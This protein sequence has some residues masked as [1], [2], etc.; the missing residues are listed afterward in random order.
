MKTELDG[1]KSMLAAKPNISVGYVYELFRAN[2][3]DAY[4]NEIFSPGK[5]TPENAL[6][7]VCPASIG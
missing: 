6:I 1:D 2:F 3:P 7:Q 5:V 4:T